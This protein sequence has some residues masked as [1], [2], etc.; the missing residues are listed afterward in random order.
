MKRMLAMLLV[1]LMLTGCAGKEPMAEQ[2]AETKPAPV[3]QVTPEPELQT[4][5]QPAPVPEPAPEPAVEEQPVPEPEIET[6]PEPEPEPEP[7]IVPE[8]DWCA[9]VQETY[10][11]VTA[12]ERFYVQILEYDGDWTDLTVIRG[13]NDWNVT[14]LEYGF[15]PQRKNG[16]CWT[17]RTATCWC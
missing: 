6:Q 16:S 14:N 10:L 3:E 1:I 4:E 2:P 8:T 12:E 7:E 5:V 11:A 9:M 13:V 17:A 15:P